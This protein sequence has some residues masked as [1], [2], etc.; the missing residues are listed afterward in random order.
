MTSLP[1]GLQS[2]F[3]LKL[4][5]HQTALCIIPPPHVSHEIDKLRS[6][7]DKAY[8]K[9]PPHLNILYP[10]VSPEKLQNAETVIRSVL[11]LQ[12]KVSLPTCSFEKSDSFSHR[13]SATVYLEPRTEDTQNKNSVSRDATD[14]HDDMSI[15]ELYTTMAV[16]FGHDQSS[17]SDTPEQPYRP[18]LTIGQTPL[19]DSARDHLKSKADLL[20]PISWQVGSLA[21]LV[22]EHQ[23]ECKNPSTRMKIWKS[24]S[25]RNPVHGDSQTLLGQDEIG[26]DDE[27]LEIGSRS[28]RKQQFELFKS[29]YIGYND[30]S[31]V[32]SNH[33]RDQDSYHFVVELGTWKA[34]NLA[35]LRNLESPKL[36]EIAVASYNVLVYSSYP[37]S[38]ERYPALLHSILSED[39]VADVLFLQEVSDDF[40]SYILSVDGIRTGWP[41]T[42]HGPPNQ[43]GVGP[44][45]NLRNIVALSRFP[46]SWEFV[47]FKRRHKGA[48]IMK[49]E[50]GEA[51][52]LEAPLVDHQSE[53]LDGPLYSDP[54]ILAGI[55]LTCGLSG[56]SVTAK[57]SQIQTLIHHLELHHSSYPWIIAG[58]FNI[59]TSSSTIDTALESKLITAETAKTLVSLETLFLEA[60][61]VDAWYTSRVRDG[62]E[63]VRTAGD[64]DL[65]GLDDGEEGA[66]YNPL[67]NRLAEETEGGGL[68]NRPQR[69]DRILFKGIGALTLQ[70]FGLFGFP[71]EVHTGDTAVS[72]PGCG[73]D[74]WGVRASFTIGVNQDEPSPALGEDTSTLPSIDLRKA[75]RTLGNAIELRDYLQKHSA[76]PSGADSD[77][78]KAAFSLVRTTLIQKPDESTKGPGFELTPPPAFGNAV[79]LILVPVGSYSLGVWSPRSDIDCLCVGP[80]SAKTFFALARQRLRRAVHLGVR[81]VRSVKAASGMM[82]EL[83][84][85]GVKLDLQYCPAVKITES[86]SQVARALPSDPLFDLSIL[87]LKKLKSYRDG[88]YLLRTIPNLSTFRVAHRLIRLWAS[89]RGILSAKFGYLGGVHI[90]L[91]LARVCKLL[92]RVASAATPSDVICTF[93]SHY[94]SFDWTK[95]MAFDPFFH[96]ARLRYQRSAREPLVILAPNTPVVNMAHTASIHSVTTLSGELKRA[97][98]VTI[99]ES[100]TWNTLVGFSEAASALEFLKHFQSYIKIDIHYWGPS[101]AKGSCLL[102]WLESRSVLLLVD[103]QKK[104]PQI[105]A[106]IWPSRFADVDANADG[107][108]E[109]QGYYLV[110]LAKSDDSAAG[111]SE[112]DVT[113]PRA[114]CTTDNSGRKALQNT[115]RTTLRAFAERIRGDEHYFDPDTSWIEVSHV[116]QSSLGDLKLDDRSWG[117]FEEDDDSSDSDEDQDILTD[118]DVFLG[119]VPLRTRETLRSKTAASKAGNA[120]S[121]APRGKLRPAADVLN[122]IRW[123]PNMD[124]NDFVVGYEDRFL[125]TK[126]VALQRWKTEQTDDEFIP[127]HRI[128]Y[129]KRRSDG[130]CVWERGSK[131]DKI[132]GSGI[133]G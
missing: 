3:T 43:P 91:L 40:L 81:I 46:F 17:S 100:A 108:K 102:G 5:S 31:L 114:P 10:F 87:S 33:S 62:N 41:F 119:E 12:E 99:S 39:A 111:L 94:A 116:T 104:L 118:E 106:R 57:E 122:R 2:P 98:A 60:D 34:N 101:L 6:H 36:K 76:I 70:S 21:I 127:Q 26:S 1:E 79:P 25:L 78:R 110:G 14:A 73:S 52:P 71:R 45:P 49:L 77:M 130:V 126:E 50:C 19:D 56:G 53:S 66:T 125:G 113:A 131:V 133:G 84:V 89:N 64:L 115:L 7:Y 121:G 9:W 112:G 23:T 28:S 54:L 37:P 44:L 42:T 27:H 86:W 123:D 30:L 124:S 63:L 93:F 85:K 83:D 75:P 51:R 24:I 55:H 105:H 68:N 120:D 32:E 47:P 97:N 22:R 16:A 18:H 20:L 90:T 65:N 103:I 29:P 80:I 96:Q 74:H 128:V 15:G 67:T 38:R 11:E 13:Q 117:D 8:R 48:I 35:T 72:D 92:F 61:M 58:D 69:Y 95:D 129:F 4:N 59:P 109:Y 107:E 132:F 88:E 82:M